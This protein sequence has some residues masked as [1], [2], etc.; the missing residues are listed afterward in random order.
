MSLEA[1]LEQLKRKLARSEERE[2]HLQAQLDQARKDIF[3]SESRLTGLLN[4]LLA[5]TQWDFD[6]QVEISALGDELDAI[7][8]GVNTLGE[9]LKHYIEQHRLSNERLRKANH[10][11]KDKNR[12]L[13]E[14]T[15]IASHD[16]QEPLR[17][18]MNYAELIELEAVELPEHL[19]GYLNFLG[20][21]TSRMQQL[22]K[23][24]LDYSRLG[25]DKH[26]E[27]VDM[28][29]V[30]E[31]VLE[32][33]DNK[34]SR[35]QVDFSIA[36]LPEVSGYKTELIL[37]LQNLV[38][39][40]LKFS[41]PDR[42]LKVAVDVVERRG[43]WV[44]SVSDNG[45]GIELKHLER[46]FKMFQRLHTNDEYQ[47]TGIG[48]AHCKKIAELHNGEIWVKSDKNLGSTFYFSISKG[49]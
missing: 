39:N 40:A 5:Y 9:E 10:R 19:R 1:Q 42:K 25:A 14:I 43:K 17:T 15:Y 28:N 11:L 21:A 27:P 45:I 33:L 36:T 49:Q 41:H 24:L 38:G 6:N 12:E 30:M 7:A 37:I 48:L 46:I 8:V 16:L 18:V 29:A 4:V 20:K 31:Q 22:V 44:F 13:Q 47:G 23:D 2:A 3:Q 35:I 32:Q 34:I 26:P